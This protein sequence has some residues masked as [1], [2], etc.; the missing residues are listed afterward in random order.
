VE[1][2]EQVQLRLHH[3]HILELVEQVVVVLV[4]VI[5]N[6]S[7]LVKMQNLQ[8]PVPVVAVVAVPVVLDRLVSL[9]SGI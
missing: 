3:Q 9:L 2:V 1:V 7:L 5:L 8:I 4:D 6:L